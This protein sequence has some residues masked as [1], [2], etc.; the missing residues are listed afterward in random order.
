MTAKYATAAGSAQAG[1]DFTPA[2]AWVTFAPG[3]TSKTVTIGVTG[4]LAREGNEVFYVNLKQA[5]GANLADAQGQGMILNRGNYSG[6]PA[7]SRIFRLNT[8]RESR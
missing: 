3:Q 1:T 5:S 4:D 7:S 2:R 6:L 8:R